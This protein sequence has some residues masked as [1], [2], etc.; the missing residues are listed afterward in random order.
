MTKQ[1]PLQIKTSFSEGKPAGQG[2]K[3]LNSGEIDVRCGI[4]IAL[5][6]VFAPLGAAANGASY[7]EV[8]RMVARS[9]TQFEIYMNLALSRCSNQ[10]EPNGTKDSAQDPVKL[11]TSVVDDSE[12]NIDFDDEDLID[13]ENEEF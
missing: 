8:E 12:E 2:A 13:L 6:C 11:V 4:E 7:Q 1:I 5:G 9:R 10:Y 3:Y